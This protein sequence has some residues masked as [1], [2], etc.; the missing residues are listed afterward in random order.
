[1]HFTGD[2]SLQLTVQEISSMLANACRPII[3]VLNNDG[4]IIENY[5]NVKTENQKYNKIP[6]W[7]YTMLAE[8]FGGDAFTAQVRTNR[9]LDEAIQQAEA[10]NK[11]RMCIIELIAADPMDAPEYL[12]RV[13]ENMIMQENKMG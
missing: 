9:E 12:H 13:R 4:Y 10:Q 1:M 7:N 8:A 2:G 5:L 11:D 3:F 6:M